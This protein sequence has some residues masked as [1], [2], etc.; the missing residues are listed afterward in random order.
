MFA[1]VHIEPGQQ[2]SPMPPQP[3]QKPV[4]E[5]VAPSKHDDPPQQRSPAWPQ[6]SQRPDTHR[7]VLF[8]Q[9]SPAQHGAPREPQRVQVP[10]AHTKDPRQGFIRLQHGPLRSPHATHLPSRHTALSAQAAP[11]AQHAPPATPHA[12]ASLGAAGVSVVLG[13]RSVT[14]PPSPPMG[15]PI[16]VSVQAATNAATKQRQTQRFTRAILPSAVIDT[17]CHLDDPRLDDDRDAVIRRARS[18]GVT[19][20]VVPAVEPDSWA[21]TLSVTDPGERWCALGLHPRWVAT[22]SDEAIDRGLAGL[23]DLVSAR[24]DVVVAVGEC[25]L[26]AEVGVPIERQ[27]RVMLAQVEAA[28]S[29][30]LP[31]ILHVY[32]AHEAAI[33][34][35]RS[36]KLPSRGGVIHAYSGGAELARAYL[37][38]GLHLSFGG[39]ITRPRARKPLESLRATPLERLLFETDA[40]DQT[41]TGVAEG[42]HR[43]EPAHLAVTVS[44]A[45]EALGMERDALERRADANARAL[46]GLWSAPP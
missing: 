28:R 22:L 35:L 8:E 14:A 11:T 13:P 1:A 9:V 39:A 29:L 20:L 16:V 26:D 44:R 37:A 24:R 19:A 43:C 42:V 4:L 31:V 3:R 25:G 18:A 10:S 34:A 30:D 45:A 27:R 12:P 40:P 23:A 17:H 41:P 36:V 7:S 46:F 33:A 21:R 5:Q 38:M 2:G 15:V 6:A 32:R